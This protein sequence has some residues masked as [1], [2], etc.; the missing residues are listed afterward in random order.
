ME[1]PILILSAIDGNAFNI[2]GACRTAARKAGWTTEQIKDL[3]TEMLKGDFDH[4]MQVAMK[5]FEVE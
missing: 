1:K 3:M 4:L 5:Y 2:M